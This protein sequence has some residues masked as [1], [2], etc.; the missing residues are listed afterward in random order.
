M[1]LDDAPEEQP[2]AIR[3]L[4][5]EPDVRQHLWSLGGQTKPPPPAIDRDFA[6]DDSR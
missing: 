6:I 5:R 2:N 1:P 4:L 3:L